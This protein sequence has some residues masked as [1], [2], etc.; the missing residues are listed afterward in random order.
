W[1][2]TT[3]DR[4]SIG[5]FEFK[6]NFTTPSSSKVVFAAS[7]PTASF[8]SDICTGTRE[9]CVTQSGS[10]VKLESLNIRVMNQPVYRKF[11][12][13]EGI[14]LC[15]V[16]N[17]GSSVT[18]PRW[19][20]L[21]RTTGTWSINQQGTYTPDAAHR[22]LPAVCYNKNGD[23]A[24]AYNISG[25]TLTPGIRYTGRKVCDTPGMMTYTETTVISGTTANGSTRYGDYNHLVIDPSDDVTFW[26]TAMHNSAST[27]STRIAAFKLPACSTS[28]TCATP[29]ALS[30][31]SVTDISAT[32]S[33]TGSS[34]A[35][36]YRAEYKAASSGTWILLDSANTSKSIL[37][38]GL[39]GLTTYD[40]RV[41]ANCSGTVSSYASAQFTTKAGCNDLFEPNE[42]R[43]TA[44]AITIGANTTAT[45]SSSTDQDWFSF[46]TTKTGGTNIS[47]DLT[48]LPADYDL[49]LY[50]SAGKLLKSSLNTG[51]ISERIYYNN[52][53]AASYTVL[54]SG[55]NGA[56][57]AN[58]C[59]NLLVSSSNST[60]TSAPGDVIVE[61]EKTTN[62][63]AFPNPSDGNIVLE[64][65]S[66]EEGK[67]EI[68]VYD[69]NGKIV[70]SETVKTIAGTN[71]CK[72][73]LAHLSDGMY[74]AV[75]TQKGKKETVRFQLSK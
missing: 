67:A 24:M 4:D 8:N 19:Y 59:Y 57:D 70:L 53:K 31:N 75:V 44:K 60:Y 37:L 61:I 56:F 51:T 47:I 13:Y 58:K 55:Y 27:W 46:S 48:T 73:T 20:E 22:W 68:S 72:K 1:T 66:V 34:A 38:S 32:I 12:D 50:S 25:S 54:V 40:W 52:T 23:I 7:L 26:F 9:Q 33:W 6:V 49:Q 41:S 16:V 63:R 17:N 62:L 14:V 36:S 10:T 39:K 35:N 21:K 5:V 42:S 71:Q 28:T 18:V 2:S 74:Q 29:T 45:V 15:H 11:S 3:A 64:F 43:T 69:I 30:S 65:E